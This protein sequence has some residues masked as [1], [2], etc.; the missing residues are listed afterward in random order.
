[1]RPRAILAIAA[2]SLTLPACTW[3][4]AIPRR[5]IGDVPAGA[6]HVRI[7]PQQETID[8]IESVI[9]ASGGR[10][11]PDVRLAGGLAR[12]TNR[13]ADAPRSPPT[14]NDPEGPLV[15][16]QP[17]DV[18]SAEAPADE[19][20]LTLADLERLALANNPTLRQAR[21]LIDEA[22][23]AWW[24]AGLYPNPVVGYQAEE[25]GND[26]TAGLQGGFFSQTI[27]TADKLDWN[28]AV[29]LPDVE[30]ARWGLEAQR[31]RVLTDVRT[32]W[33]ELAGV[34]RIV[35]RAGELVD[36]AEQAVAASRDALAVGQVAESDVLLTEVELNGVRVLLESARA[37]EFAARRR[38]TALAGIP[39]LPGDVADEEFEASADVL[40]WDEELHTLLAASPL[41]QQARLQ[42]QRARNRIGREQA[43][44]VPDVNVQLG[45]SH[46]FATDFTLFSAQVGVML[47][48][49]NRNQGAIAAAV[50]EL[51]RAEGEVER[52]ELALRE[53][54][55]EAFGRYEQARV[56]VELFGEARDKAARARE[57]TMQA[58]EAGE[59]N[60]FRLLLVQRQVFDTEV[61]YIQALVE[62]RQ[63]QALVEGLLLEGGLANPASQTTRSLGQTMQSPTPLSSGPARL[64]L[65]PQTPQ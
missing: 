38:L 4:Y 24:Q 1:M 3:R 42:V 35:D 28:R 57:M 52:V 21:A 8:A 9:P 12:S 43:Q 6:R 22:A 65:T 23:G 13:G 50:A 19:A 64:S 62:L 49:H 48:V 5:T 33:Y 17:L 30:Q 25:I 34:A 46:D 40:A 63:S 53:R 56:Q 18:S 39:E 7:E 60:I 36:L 20:P 45:S 44:P 54:L 11:P 15:A 61:Q 51:M 32:A 16:P 47:P 37:R 58:R 41:V 2:L 14:D 27:V 26:D 29:L 31:L 55:A 10:E 59:F